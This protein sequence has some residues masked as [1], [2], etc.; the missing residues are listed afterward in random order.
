MQVFE[1]KSFSGIENPKNLATIL[2]LDKLFFISNNLVCGSFRRAAPFVEHLRN[3]KKIYYKYTKEKGQ[4]I[5][6]HM[7]SFCYIGS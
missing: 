4:M 2:I 6:S 1:N 7:V 5:F 3:G